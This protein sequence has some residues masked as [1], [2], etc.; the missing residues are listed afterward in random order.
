MYFVEKISLSNCR[1]S[2]EVLVPPECCSPECAF[3]ATFWCPNERKQ[4]EMKRD[5]R[6]M[7]GNK[8]KVEGSERKIKENERKL[9]ET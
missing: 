3:D 1:F 4:N 5:E 2:G 7:K 9:K 8:R 6:E